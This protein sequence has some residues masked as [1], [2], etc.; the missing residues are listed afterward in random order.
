MELRIVRTFEWQRVPGQEIR[1]GG[2]PPAM[3]LVPTDVLQW[4]DGHT[5]DWVDVPVV[6]M[7]RPPHPH[8]E[9]NRRARSGLNFTG[10]KKTGA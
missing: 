7:E 2:G 6:E 1:Y 4:R 9:R 8:E 3:H 5:Q 10:I